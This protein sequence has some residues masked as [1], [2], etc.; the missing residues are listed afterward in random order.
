[1]RVMPIG[2]N[3]ATRRVNLASHARRRRMLRAGFRTQARA[4]LLARMMV[5]VISALALASCSN[6]SR[7]RMISG[8]VY[9]K[10]FAQPGGVSPAAS[11]APFARA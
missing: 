4:Y 6:I 2:A 1:M 11:K 9:S 5:V 10:K 3:R 8:T 7:T